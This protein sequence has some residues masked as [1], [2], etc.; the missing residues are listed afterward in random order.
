MG[1]EKEIT[2]L[3]NIAFEIRE[4]LIKLA[5]KKTIHIGGDLSVTEIVTVLWHYVMKYDVTNPKWEERDRFLLSKGHCAAAVEFCQ[6]KLGF[7]TN[8]EVFKEYATDNCR[9]SMAPCKHLNPFFETSATGSLGQGLS[10]AV[11]MAMALKAKGNNR[12][13]VYVVAGDGEMQEGS[14]WEAIMYASQMMLDNLCL[15]LDN[16]GLQF[17]GRTQ[18]I[19]SIENIE[20]RFSAF[21]WKVY[22]VDGH[23]ISDLMRVFDD[24]EASGFPVLINALTVKGKG[25]SYME[26]NYLWH[27]GKIENDKLDET[28]NEL[29]CNYKRNRVNV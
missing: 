23:S 8:E 1:K 19:V 5:N 20:D 12:S 27:A 10:I 13:R 21:G 15:I 24:M 11:G 28:L 25:V 4:N 16:N 29:Y 3:E 9:F 2:R 22:S 7:F 17:D 26:N 14:N 18:E 6:S